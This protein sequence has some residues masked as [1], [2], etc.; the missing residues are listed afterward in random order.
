MAVDVE[1]IYRFADGATLL[2]RSRETINLTP[3]GAHGRDE[4]TG[5][6]EIAEGT[7]RF[8]GIR[9]RFTFRAVMGMDRQAD[10]MLGDSFLSGRAEV[11]LAG[12]RQ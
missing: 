3:Q 8:A 6:G 5:E 10:G 4:W 12:P 1:S 9:G 2:M 7:G 11:T